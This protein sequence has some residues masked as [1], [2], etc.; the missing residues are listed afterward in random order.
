VK[1][2]IGL[3]GGTF[4]PPHFGHLHLANEM[5]TRHN[6]D[7]V[8]FIPAAIAPHKLSRPPISVEHRVKMVELAIEGLPQFKLLDLEV[9]RGGTSYT[10]DTI[11]EILNDPKLGAE[12]EFFLIMSDEYLPTLGQ[13]KGIEEIVEKVVLLIGRRSA[14]RS[15]P[16]STGIPAVD[17][18][19]NKGLNNM[20]VLEIR[21]TDIRDRVRDHLSCRHLVP[22]RVL[23]YLYENELYT[24]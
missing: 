20:A 13:W 24:T 6:L 12:S 5:L 10:I 11:N 23:S 9:K 18:A 1:R 19:V 16:P 14:D 17:A 15:P 8:W 2:R 21:A 4:D 3:Y 7:E 22:A